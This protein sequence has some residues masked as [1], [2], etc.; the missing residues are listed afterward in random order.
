MLCYKCTWKVLQ[1]VL[2]ECWGGHCLVYMQSC[3]CD[4]YGRKCCDVRVKG[5][6]GEKIYP[7]NV[8]VVS[9]KTGRKTAKTLQKWCLFQPWRVWLHLVWT[10]F[11][12]AEYGLIQMQPNRIW[13]KLGM[14]SIGHAPNVGAIGA[15]SCNYEP[16]ICCLRTWRIRMAI[17]N[18]NAARPDMVQMK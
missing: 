1:E 5:K 12:Q 8:N 18:Q 9:E 2:I 7:F 3:K 13:S 4:R 10:K 15:Y 11:S 14:V 6:L 16:H 17:L